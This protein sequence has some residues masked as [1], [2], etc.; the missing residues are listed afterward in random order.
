MQAKMKEQYKQILHF[1]AE[2]RSWVLLCTLSRL[3]LRLITTCWRINIE[4]N[5][6]NHAT[7]RIFLV[8]VSISWCNNDTRR[9]KMY[10][11]LLEKQNKTFTEKHYKKMFFKSYSG[12]AA[13]LLVY[14]IFQG[15]QAEDW[16]QDCLTA[17]RHTTCGLRCHPKWATSPP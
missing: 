16:T 7:K 1:F 10:R 9:E 15:A 6:L 17:A 8:D 12:H 11:V 4:P 5:L 13:T 14:F 3:F 2:S